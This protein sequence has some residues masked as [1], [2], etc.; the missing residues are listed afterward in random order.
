MAV[1][2]HPTKG[3][4]YWQIIISN[5]RKSKQQ[6]YLFK[7]TK[8]EAKRHEVFIKAGIWEGEYQNIE[9]SM[10]KIKYDEK[11]PLFIYFIQQGNAGPIK[12][13]YTKYDLYARFKR[14]QT[15]NPLPLRVLAIIDG[16]DT[17]TEI[18]LHTRFSSCRLNGEW[19]APTEELIKF[20]NEIRNR[21]NKLQLERIYKEYLA[22][23]S[24]LADNE[25]EIAIEALQ[26][27]NLKDFNRIIDKITT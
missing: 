10:S 17:R 11:K 22:A 23:V 19:F 20:I 24:K 4:G 14:L 12:I 27:G 13:G 16:A 1:R 15:G 7:G 9:S 21:S 2:Q 5:G 6:V 25:K 26:S 18:S 3:D 8:E